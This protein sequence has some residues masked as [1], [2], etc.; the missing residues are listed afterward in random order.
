VIHSA[1]E[2]SP[3]PPQGVIMAWYTAIEE[4]CHTASR[5][6]EIQP[7]GSPFEHLLGR[8]TTRLLILYALFDAVGKS[9][10]YGGYYYSVQCN[11]GSEPVKQCKMSRKTP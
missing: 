2:V 4:R 5:R 7:L 6:A 1:A 11:M 9:N 8:Q 10:E 3:T